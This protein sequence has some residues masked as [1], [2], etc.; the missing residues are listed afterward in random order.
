MDITRKHER[1]HFGRKFACSHIQKLIKKCKI[2]ICFHA[3]MLSF[4]SLME[5]FIMLL[6]YVVNGEK[7]ERKGH[8][9]LAIIYT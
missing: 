8:S 2:S 5:F 6:R 9:W 1:R 4:V 7:V 3:F